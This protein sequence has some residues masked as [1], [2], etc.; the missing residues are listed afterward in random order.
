[1]M[2]K[3]NVTLIELWLMKDGD[4]ELVESVNQYM[5][6][7]APEFEVVNMDDKYRCNNWLIVVCFQTY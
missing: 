2:T 4:D 6:P 7:L 1:M 3:M 5:T